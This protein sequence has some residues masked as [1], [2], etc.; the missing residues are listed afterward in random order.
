MATSEEKAFC[1]LQF[2]KTEFVVAVQR[3]FRNKLGCDSPSD[4][5]VRRWYH[6][7]EDAG[8]LCKEKSTG[9]AQSDLTPCDFYLWGFIKDRVY[10]PPLPADLLELGN[11]TE[12]AVATITE[13]TLLNVWEELGYRLDVCRVTNGAHIEHL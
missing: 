9:R 7:Y 6:Q 10:M 3:A 12:A 4:N 2:A 11:R 13:N 8:C 5:D 1:G